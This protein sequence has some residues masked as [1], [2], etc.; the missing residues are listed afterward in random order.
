MEKRISRIQRLDHVVY[1]G[2]ASSSG[3]SRCFKVVTSSPR[4]SLP[5]EYPEQSFGVCLRHE[6]YF[7]LPPE[8]NYRN[9][10]SIL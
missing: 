8:D 4:T 7:G 2:A 9:W 3:T 1:V 5:V 6:S 10:L